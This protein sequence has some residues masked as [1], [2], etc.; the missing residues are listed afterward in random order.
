MNKNIIYFFFLTVCLLF[1]SFCTHFDQDLIVKKPAE[2]KKPVKI[3]FFPFQDSRDYPG[4]GSYICELFTGYAISM[5]QWE[6]IDYSLATKILHEKKLSLS[7]LSS[8]EF[9]DFSEFLDADIIVTGKV[10]SFKKILKF[11]YKFIS[12]RTKE[13]VAKGVVTTNYP[14]LSAMERVMKDFSDSLGQNIYL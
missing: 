4:S 5:P 7:G 14:V 13:V 8:N 6:I 3:I 2:L 12:V 1:V 11:Q 10:I 9:P